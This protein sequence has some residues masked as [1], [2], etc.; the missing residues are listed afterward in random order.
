VGGDEAGKKEASCR[1]ASF[2]LSEPGET[3]KTPSRKFFIST[4][5]KPTPPAGGLG[6]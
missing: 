6:G 4:R 1:K 3:Y 2:F 5:R